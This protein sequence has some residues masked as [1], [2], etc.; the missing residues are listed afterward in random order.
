LGCVGCC[1]FREYCCHSPFNVQVE[2]TD[3]HSSMSTGVD[4]DVRAIVERWDVMVVGLVIPVWLLGNVGE[5]WRRDVVVPWWR[6]V[7][8][9]VAGLWRASYFIVPVSVVA[10]VIGIHRIA[11]S[12]GDVDPVPSFGSVG[13]LVAQFRYHPASDHAKYKQTY[14]FHVSSPCES[15]KRTI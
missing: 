8:A 14:S 15:G 1:G 4:V 12:G 5:A 7:R 3:C 13:L 9:L 10:G 6:D 2:E 11:G